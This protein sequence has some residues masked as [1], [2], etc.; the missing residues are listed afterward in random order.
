MKT[1]TLYGVGVG[2]GDPELLTLK[3]ARIVRE[4]PVI[5]VPVAKPGGDSY[6]LSVVSGLLRSEQRVLPLVFPMLKDLNE[7]VKYRAAAAETIWRELQTGADVAF[8]TEGDPLFHSTFIYVLNE[9]P[10]GAPVEI[11]PGVSSINAAAAQAQIPLVSAD[12]RLAVVPAIFED[13]A[14]IRRILQEFDT[15]VFLKFRS[16]LDQLLDILDEMDLVESSILVERASHTDGRVVRDVRS[17]RGSDVHYLS[18]LIVQTDRKIR[19]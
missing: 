13:K 2:P 16:M 1:G 18:L 3:A 14:D 6:A 7:K 5:A 12:Q 9:L 4:A 8:L 19:P 17:L 10:A 11:V 15:V